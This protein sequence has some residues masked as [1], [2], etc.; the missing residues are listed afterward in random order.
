MAL[1]ICSLHICGKG[2]KG[3]NRGCPHH[4]HLPQSKTS[5]VLSKHQLPFFLPLRTLVVTFTKSELY[6]V[7]FPL[8]Q[9]RGRCCYEAAHFY[10]PSVSGIY[11][12]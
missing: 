2:E 1:L 8:V 9:I 12:G 3:E 7:N 6:S 11:L 10:G 4:C 5:Q